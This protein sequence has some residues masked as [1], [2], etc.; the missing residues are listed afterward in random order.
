M[1]WNYKICY[2]DM[3]PHMLT[4]FMFACRATWTIV[5]SHVVDI[6][7]TCHSH[8]IEFMFTCMW[9]IILYPIISMP[10]YYLTSPSPP[11]DH[12]LVPFWFLS[13][14]FWV[15]FR[16]TF[17]LFGLLWQLVGL[18]FGH[19]RS[20]F[21]TF[22]ITVWPL[23]GHLL[24]TFWNICWLLFCRFLGTFCT[25]FGNRFWSLLRCLFRSLF[26]YF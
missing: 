22:W 15:T 16:I 3:P 10:Q 24:I 1:L 20:L 23:F 19:F 17:S 7:F 5:A 8:L 9:I 21:F 11:F 2:A 13:C 26:G 6:M 4:S 18:L 25:T 12:L 14:Y